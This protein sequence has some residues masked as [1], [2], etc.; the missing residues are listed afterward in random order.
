MRSKI[1]AVLGGGLAALA[2]SLPASAEPALWKVQGPHA[3]VYLFGTVHVLKST[4]QWRSPKI[5][6]AFDAAG[7][8][9]EEVPDA[10]NAAG[11]QALIM[12]YGVDPAHPLSSQLDAAGKAKLTAFETTYGLPDAGIEMLR[13]WLAAVTF[14][15][16]PVMKAG[17]DPK[18]GVDL[19]LKSMAD[20]AHKPVL[21]FETLDQQM[22]F[23][24]DL[25]QQQQ[26]DFLLATL[27]DADGATAQLSRMVDAWSAGD[28]AALGTLVNGDLNRYPALYNV[29]VVQRNRAFAKRIE[30]LLRGNGVTFVAIGG[31]HLS[32]PDSVQ[33]DLA[34]DGIQ[35][36]R[37]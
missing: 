25:P 37:Q 31:G 2:L 22:H 23:F 33:V 10:D 11:A 6:A 3:T 30:Q 27:D 13:P 21:G 18:S 20:A 12:Q 1:L 29:L 15:T 19:M 24:A 16:L 4:T 32:G 7:T 34:K 5:Q 28:V 36:V 8:L 26:I 35:A 17:Y 9:W 14:S